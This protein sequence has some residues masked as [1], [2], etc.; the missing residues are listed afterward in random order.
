MKEESADKSSTIEHIIS[1]HDVVEATT[2]WPDDKGKQNLDHESQ[3]SLKH[4]VPVD[5]LILGREQVDKG[6]A[7]NVFFKL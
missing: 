5:S 6:D 2:R 4:Q 1:L 3:V 7:V